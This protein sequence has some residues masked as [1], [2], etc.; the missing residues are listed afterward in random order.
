MKPSNKALD[1][2]VSAYLCNFFLDENGVKTLKVLKKAG[3]EHA[4]L[5]SADAVN[6]LYMSSQLYMPQTLHTDSE[7]ASDAD[8]SDEQ[9]LRILTLTLIWS[10]SFLCPLW[11]AYRDCFHVFLSL[12]FLFRVLT[13]RARHSQPLF[14]TRTC[15]LFL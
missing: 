3:L 8:A 1:G 13:W 10:K 15:V 7:A 14:A 11:G 5:H 2:A 4:D 9:L 12:C 6:A